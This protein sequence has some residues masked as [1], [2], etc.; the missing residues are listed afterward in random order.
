M[1]HVRVLGAGSG[2]PSATR[3]TSGLWIEAVDAD[4]PRAEVRRASVQPEGA[5]ATDRGPWT[6][7]TRRTIGPPA[8]PVPVPTASA[9]GAGVLIDCPGSVVH[10]LATFGMPLA[11]VRLVIL[12]HDHVDHVYGLPH[13]LHARA[14]AEQIDQL[15]IFGPRQTLDTVRAMIA[16]HGLEGPRYGPVALHIVPPESGHSVDLDLGRNQDALRADVTSALSIRSTPADHARETLALRVDER[17]AH[18]ATGSGA[19]PPSFGLSSDTRPSSTIAELCRGVDLLLH[20]CGGLHSEL[21]ELEA[22]HSSARQAGEVARLAEARELALGHLS[23]CTDQQSE[24]WLAEAANTFRGPVR[25][26]SDGDL[27]ELR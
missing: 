4:T 20:D 10:K 7:A 16:V 24:L 11:A 13:L 19:R 14:I 15:D 21:S 25:L 6:A 17:V 18:A 12:T 27:Y 26:A 2:L 23:P 1:L 5:A 22:P 8:T 9:R 3:D